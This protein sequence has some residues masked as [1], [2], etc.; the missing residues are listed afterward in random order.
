MVAGASWPIHESARVEGEGVRGHGPHSSKD[1]LI[2]T[3]SGLL[4]WIITVAL[5]VAISG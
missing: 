3:I 2:A 5:K 4:A 1:L